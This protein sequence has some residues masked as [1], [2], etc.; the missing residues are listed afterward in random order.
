[1]RKFAVVLSMLCLV[2]GLTAATGIA[3]AQDNSALHVT[4]T[5]KNL[6]FGTVPVGDKLTKHVILANRGD[7]PIAIE[8]LSVSGNIADFQL[9]AHTCGK[10]LDAGKS[11]TISLQFAPVGNTLGNHLVSG[12]VSVTLISELGSQVQAAVLSGAVER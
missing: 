2:V 8:R 5:P 7:A 10:T 9:V 6:N 11:C 1:M 12:K 4:L 3:A